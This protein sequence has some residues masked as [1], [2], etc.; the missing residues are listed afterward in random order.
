VLSVEVSFGVCQIQVLSVVHRKH[1]A[2]P[3]QSSEGGQALRARDGSASSAAHS[4]SVARVGKSGDKIT[5]QRSAD[6]ARAVPGGGGR[7]RKWNR[8]APP[9]PPC[10]MWQCFGSPD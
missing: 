9:P 7:I 4:S 1:T 5:L 10:P 3:L 8:G 2:S 6:V